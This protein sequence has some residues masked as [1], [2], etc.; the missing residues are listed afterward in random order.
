MSGRWLRTINPEKLI[1]KT[2]FMAIYTKRG[3]RGKTSIYQLKREK[4]AYVNKDDTRLQ[5]IGSLDEANSFLGLVTSFLSQQKDVFKLQKIQG[6]LF[7]I[8]SI[9]A[10]VDGLRF[11]KTKVKMLEMEIDKLEAGLPRLSNFILPGGSPAS[12]LLQISRAIVRR[13]E[14]RLV[15]LDKIEPLRPQIIPYIN[16]LSDFLFIL[17]RKINK[18][19]GIKEKIWPGRK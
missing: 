2:L 11:P 6:D 5:V 19:L 1:L 7:L 8:G 15:G 17:A 4:T 18:D 9:L 10:G 16:R 14:R 3:D 13:V 12:S